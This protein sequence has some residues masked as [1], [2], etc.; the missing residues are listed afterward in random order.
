M[1]IYSIYLTQGIPEANLVAL[2]G[3]LE[4][5]YEGVPVEMDGYEVGSYFLFFLSFP[6]SHVLSPCIYL[7][8]L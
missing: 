3:C 5:I 4:G 7:S 6:L 8:Q 1:N 2:A